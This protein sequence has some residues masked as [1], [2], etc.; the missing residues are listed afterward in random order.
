MFNQL[1]TTDT[2]PNE[3][4]ELRRDLLETAVEILQNEG[5]DAL[6]MRRLAD[7]CDT[8][9]N[10][11]YTIFGGKDDLL[12]EIFDGGRF[13]LEERCREVPEDLPPLER[14]YRLGRAFRDFALDHSTIY[15]A[16]HSSATSQEFEWRTSVFSMFLETIEDCIEAGILP[17]HVEPF[18]VTSALNA[19]AH[20]AISLQ[21]SGFY[22]NEEQASDHY[23]EILGA[24]FD[25]FRVDEPTQ[26]PP[27]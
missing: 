2:E 25:G 24:T 6:T 11:I 27:S 3:H 13:L 9:T 18:D 15:E 14:L 22:D 5:P 8:S 4:D 19:A 10:M 16:I 21:L 23:D 7:K 20:G 17:D 26:L 1:G 12:R